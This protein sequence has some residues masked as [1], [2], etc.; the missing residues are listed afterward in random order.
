MS[1][2]NE[3]SLDVASD[4]HMHIIVLD[5]GETY[6]GIKEAFVILNAINDDEEFRLD[7]CSQKYSVSEL[8]SA[9]LANQATVKNLQLNL[10]ATSDEF[11]EVLNRWNELIQD[12]FND[13]QTR[14]ID[15]DTSCPPRNN[16]NFEDYV[17]DHYGYEMFCDI[18]D[19]NKAIVY[20]T[21]MDNQQS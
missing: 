3:V 10:S 20:I 16:P 17:E 14:M 2:F 4:E 8:I 18:S 21:Q 9:Y 13:W 5:D 11:E 7:E 1:N 12:V 6:G 15:N 19:A